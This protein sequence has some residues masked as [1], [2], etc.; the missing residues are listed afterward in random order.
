[1]LD[2]I[3]DR[4][5][6]NVV[7]GRLQVIR[8]PSSRLTPRISTGIG[9]ESTSPRHAGFQPVV[10]AARPDARSRVCRNS[11]TAV[12]SSATAWSSRPSTS[13]PP[14]ASCRCARRS[15]IP[16]ETSRSWAPSCRS[17][18]SRCRSSY[19]ARSMRDRLASTSRNACRKPRRS[20]ITSIVGAAAAA[21]SRSSSRDVR[22]GVDKSDLLVRQANRHRDRNRPRAA[23]RRDRRRPADPRRGR[24]RA[25]WSRRARAATPAS[26]C[27]GRAC[28]V[29]V[30]RVQLRDCRNTPPCAQGRA[31]GRRA[32]AAAPA[33]GARSS[34]HNAVA[35]TAATKGIAGEEQPGREGRR[36][37]DPEHDARRRLHVS[38][39]RRAAGRPRTGRAAGQRWRSPSGSRHRRAQ[40]QR[41]RPRRRDGSRRTPPT[42]QAASAAAASPASASHFICCAHVG[43]GAS[44]AT[45]E[46]DRR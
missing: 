8:R 37:E 42:R 10:E 14:F 26:S 32:A 27:S 20:R 30:C 33:V 34:A 43:A 29:A 22:P 13:T 19:P 15:A 36:R 23:R 5:A 1:M 6:R 24:R 16:S 3:G 21:I 9:T 28:A 39:S 31:S 25:A 11:L 7:R 12:P 46:R 4:F 40:A 2:R 44:V 17:R 35:A 38:R 45:Y 41:K 18:S